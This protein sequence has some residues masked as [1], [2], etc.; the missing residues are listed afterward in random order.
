MKWENRGLLQISF[1]QG[2]TFLMDNGFKIINV[3]ILKPIRTLIYPGITERN[4]ICYLPKYFEI[5]CCSFSVGRSDYSDLFQ[6]L[7]EANSSFVGKLHVN[8]GLSWRYLD[9]L[10][11]QTLL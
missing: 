8:L 6:G 9:N 11:T 2:E 3:S 7:G 4:N 10:H 1:T 5:F